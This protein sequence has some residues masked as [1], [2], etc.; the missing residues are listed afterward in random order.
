MY[1]VT[2]ACEENLE[3]YISAISRLNSRIKWPLYTYITCKSVENELT[4]LKSFF[5]QRQTGMSRNGIL[6]LLDSIHDYTQYRTFVSLHRELIQVC[7]RLEGDKEGEGPYT[8][9]YFVYKNQFQAIDL[10][11]C[12]A[13][14][15][16]CFGVYTHKVLAY[17]FQLGN[18]VTAD[19]GG[20]DG[21]GQFMNFFF[22]RT[23]IFLEGFRNIRNVLT[24]VSLPAGCRITEKN[25][26]P[27]KGDMHGRGKIPY[28]IDSGEVK[29]V[30]KPRDMRLDYLIMEALSFFNGFL[31][32][33]Y[34]LPVLQ[35]HLLPDNTGLMQFAIHAEEMDEEQAQ[36]YFL[37]FGVL[38]YFSKLFG[39]DDLHTENIMAT[40]QGPVIIDLE[41]ALMP[42]LIKKR[43]IANDNLARVAEAFREKIKENATFSVKRS[44]KQE[45]LPLRVFEA[46]ILEGFSYAAGCCRQHKQELEG[47]YEN[48]RKQPFYYRVVPVHTSGFYTYMHD[49]ISFSTD[50]SQVGAILR[51]AFDEIADDL[52]EK[53]LP[54]QTKEDFIGCLE[55]GV[56]VKTMHTG[57]FWGNIPLFQFIDTV[58]EYGNIF[59][60]GYIDGVPLFKYPIPSGPLGQLLAEFSEQIDWLASEEAAQSVRGLL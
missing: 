48:M 52:H 2:D 39:I 7:I 41:C 5:L 57:M 22:R 49:L 37:K 18:Y 9:F 3:A 43:S 33:K 17:L 8:F 42:G 23:D 28:I 13:G 34:R 26:I 4:L 40:L 1:R 45:F 55:A 31:G 15:Y 44:E 54:S 30:Y 59:C 21:T 29:F 36:A 10:L 58:D 27:T 24:G 32:E 16:G 51:Y 50:N 60:M 6:I 46:S 11:N 35:I 56:L 47:Y 19:G 38:L 53:Y 14:I 20:P 12:A 25:M